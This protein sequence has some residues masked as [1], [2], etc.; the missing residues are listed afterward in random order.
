VYPRYTHGYPEL[1]RQTLQSL[2]EFV[3]SFG[4]IYFLRTHFLKL[5][6]QVTK[7]RIETKILDLEDRLT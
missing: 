6:L 3:G 1:Y 4:I 5:L 7:T 2:V